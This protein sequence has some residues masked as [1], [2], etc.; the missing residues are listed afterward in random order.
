M[1]KQLDGAFL[2]WARDWLTDESVVLMSPAAKGIYIDLLCHC[3]LEGS[4]PACPTQCSRIARLDAEAFAELWRELAP[5]FVEHASEPGRLVNKRME[6]ERSK[7]ED[8]RKTRSDKAKAAAQARWDKKN[9][10]PKRNARGNARSNANASGQALLGDAHQTKPSTTPLTPQGEGPTPDGVEARPSAAAE[11]EPSRPV[12]SRDRDDGASPIADV[13]KALMATRYRAGVTN[14]I[15]RRGV[16][17]SEARRLVANGLTPEDVVKL[18]ELAESKSSGDPGALLAHWLDNDEWR[19]VLDEAASKT[20]ERGLRD[21]Q[22]PDP[23]DPGSE[24]KTAAS[25]LDGV[26][27]RQAEG[28]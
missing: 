14:G 4:I 5:L 27:P 26:M 12:K 17:G 24:P 6:E 20:K 1:T 16:V 7:Q 11:P 18:A 3:W 21:R 2:F 28:A 15:A 23:D 8:R 19:S 22:S 13:T 25:V 10:Q 9:K